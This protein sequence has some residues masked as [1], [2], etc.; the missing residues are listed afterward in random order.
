MVSRWANLLETGAIGRQATGNGDG[1]AD[2]S[3][4]AETTHRP[5]GALQDT[6]KAQIGRR[7]D[8]VVAAGHRQ[9]DDAGE[10]GE[11]SDMQLACIL[12]ETSAVST[13]KRELSTI[14]GCAASEP[15]SRS[16]GKVCS[17]IVGPE[18]GRR[19]RLP[20]IN[21]LSVIARR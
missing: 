5:S 19:R 9:F 10:Q 13:Q 21:P 17:S 12:R 20:A 1:V 11:R 16:W 7:D 15:V 18:A 3:W 2:R 8:L 4:F 6:L 14:P